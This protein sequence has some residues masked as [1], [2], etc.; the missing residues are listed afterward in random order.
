MLCHIHTPV[1]HN[2]TPLCAIQCPPALRQLN[3][4]PGAGAGEQE[5][6]LSISLQYMIEAEQLGS[7]T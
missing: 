3:T 4:A 2:K 6:W 1:F 7:G 5:V